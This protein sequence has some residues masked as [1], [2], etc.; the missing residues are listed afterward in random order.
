MCGAAYDLWS[1]T[2]AGV[3]RTLQGC[4]PLPDRVGADNQ[5]SEDVV[6]HRVEG[7]RAAVID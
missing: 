7:D 3:L 4:P 1:G 6:K 5:G 2:I